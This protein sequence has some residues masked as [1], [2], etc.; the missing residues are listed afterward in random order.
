MSIYLFI[1]S[2]YV[3]RIFFIISSQKKS[4]FSSDVYSMRVGSMHCIFIH[5]TI[6]LEAHI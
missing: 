1:S 2:E 6:Y 5:D 3:D 4:Y